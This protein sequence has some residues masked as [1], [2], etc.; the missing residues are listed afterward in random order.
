MG[1]RES[2][3]GRVSLSVEWSGANVER[4]GSPSAVPKTGERLQQCESTALC[5]RALIRDHHFEA[6]QLV[7]VP[8]DLDY[9]AEG[10]W[11]STGQLT[12]G[13]RRFDTLEH[14]TAEKFS[15]SLLSDGR[16]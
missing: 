6:T 1:K 14:E 2:E 15:A 7:R 4:R 16:S 8:D 12:R 9:V 11:S 13:N 10:F 3:R 5:R